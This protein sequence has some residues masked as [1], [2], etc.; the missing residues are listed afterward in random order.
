MDAFLSPVTKVAV[1]L[2]ARILNATTSL[3]WGNMQCFLRLE[4]S[5]LGKILPQCGLRYRHQGRSYLQVP[6]IHFQGGFNV[7]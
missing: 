5:A 2:D 4:I 3:N 7:V 6:A 1:V